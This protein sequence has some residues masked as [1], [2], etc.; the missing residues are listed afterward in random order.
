MVKQ[1]LE[2]FGGFSFGSFSKPITASFNSRDLGSFR[3]GVLWQ[4][5]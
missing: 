5:E 2:L 3:E 4:A 1:I